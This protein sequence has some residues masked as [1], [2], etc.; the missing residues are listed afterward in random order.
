M[1]NLV[2]KV[3]SGAR[4]L[5]VGT[6]I[7]LAALAYSPK[8]ADGVVINSFADLINFYSGTY[9]QSVQMDVYS[10]DNLMIRDLD[11]QLDSVVP[12]DGTNVW[13]MGFAKYDGAGMVFGGYANNDNNYS[14]NYPGYEGWCGGYFHD[15]VFAEGDVADEVMI[16]HD[17][18]GDG[19]G[20]VD[21]GTWTLGADDVL[22]W[23]RDIE[24]NGIQGGIE[25]LGS[26]NY[27]VGTKVLP[28]MVINSIPGDLD[29]DGDVDIF[30]FAIFQPN[31]GKSGMTYDEGDLDGNGTVDVFDWAI[32]QPNYGIGGEAPAVVPEPAT[33]A[34]LGLGAGA[35]ALKRKRE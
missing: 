5:V 24:F 16:I 19:I 20:S 9:S 6:A 31:Y 4:N 30:D 7:G 18:L 29:H 14:N 21:G 28:H 32:F 1:K 26:F 2:D 3:K 25:E 17:Q 10:P 23:T 8:V 27:G 15:G 33:G 22:Y 13:R 35:L 34:L 11:T 12:K